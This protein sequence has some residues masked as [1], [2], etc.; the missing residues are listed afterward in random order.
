MTDGSYYS[1]SSAW[2]NSVRNRL[3]LRPHDIVELRDIRILER[4]KSNYAATG[5]EMVMTWTHGAFRATAAEEGV[6]D[7]HDDINCSMIREAIRV[8]AET[9][10]A[11]SK[12]PS[13]ALYIYAA[14]I[15]G[16]TGEE[17]RRH[18]M[19]RYLNKLIHEGRVKIVSGQSR[20]NGLYAAERKKFNE[21]DL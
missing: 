18:E 5:E 6:A 12:Y 9:G 10:T 21:N 15:K 2:N 14:G 1:G 7:R 19:T 20:G 3:G 17:I 13:G 16:H 8:Q 4:L 11:F